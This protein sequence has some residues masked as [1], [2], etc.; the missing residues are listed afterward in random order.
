MPPARKILAERLTAQ[1]L[2]GPPLEGAE[3]VAGRLLAVQGQDPRGARLAVRARTEGLAASDVDRALTEERSVLI[4]WLN[5]GT[6]HLVR[7]EDYPWLQALM[8]P[9]LITA[10]SRRLQQEG[11]SADEAVRAV[12]AIAAVLGADG[13]LPRAQLK[14]RLE[15]AGIRT[16]AMLQLVHRAAIEGIVVRGPMIGRQ[17]AYALV[18]DWLDRPPAFERETALAELGRRFLAGHAPAG[19]RDLARWAGLPLRDARAAL[20][21]IAGEIEV[22]GDGMVRLRRSVGE[23]ELPPP[24]LLGAFDPVLL[25][26]AP[27]EPLLGAHEP[28]II[29]GGMF[30]PF[31]TVSGRAVGTWRYA[32]GAVELGKLDAISKRARARL[33]AD[34]ADVERFLAG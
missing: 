3:G 19:E 15:A 10:S 1:A 21:V 28:A 24:R 4:T 26:W 25:G 5:R 12:A 11:V 29:Q 22:D 6:L 8:T 17:H 16:E 27:R 23:C 20:A 14:E 33:A 32:K 9:P 13:P 7:S 31:A 2:S 30:N 34:A 18:D